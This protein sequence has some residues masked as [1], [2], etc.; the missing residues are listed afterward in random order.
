MLVCGDPKNEKQTKTD[1]LLRKYL[2]DVEWRLTELKMKK[3]EDVDKRDLCNRAEHV[4]S[5]FSFSIQIFIFYF[6]TKT[7][8]NF[9]CGCVTK[10]KICLKLEREWC[11]VHTNLITMAPAVSSTRLQVLKVNLLWLFIRMG[12][13]VVNWVGVPFMCA[14]L[15]YGILYQLLSLI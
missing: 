5:V 4:N 3:W 6:K 7:E 8:K 12:N 2:L 1:K 11:A 10:T 13:C 9:S 15:Y 14:I